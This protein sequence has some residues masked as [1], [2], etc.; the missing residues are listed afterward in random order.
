MLQEI[1]LRITGATPG[2][3]RRL[4]AFFLSLFGVC[5][6]IQP[7]ATDIFAKLTDTGLVPEPLLQKI[8]SYLIAGA[9]IGAFMS[10]LPVTNYAPIAEAKEE[11]AP[12]NPTP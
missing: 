4:R 2:F 10:S 5:I 12:T 3:F 9:A 7:F 11:D 6:A 1:Y 8:A